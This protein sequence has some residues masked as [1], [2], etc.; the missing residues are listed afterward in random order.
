MPVFGK[1]GALLESVP[2]E[3]QIFRPVGG[4]VPAFG[5]EAFGDA[6]NQHQIR[7]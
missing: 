7:L 4:Q 3:S 6:I 5:N 1:I 2:L